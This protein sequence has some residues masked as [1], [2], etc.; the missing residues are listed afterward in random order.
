MQH[1]LTVN[2]RVVSQS[3][4]EKNLPENSEGEGHSEAERQRVSQKNIS[5]TTFSFKTMN[6][7]TNKIR[8]NDKKNYKYFQFFVFWDIL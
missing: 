1:I 6:I 4:K 3:F 8:I 2:Y 7:Y 5:K